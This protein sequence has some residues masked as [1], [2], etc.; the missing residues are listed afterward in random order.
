MKTSFI[1]VYEFPA[2]DGGA[3]RGM[4]DMHTEN[5]SGLTLKVFMDAVE[6]LNDRFKG[7]MRPGAKVN[8]LNIIRLDS[9]Q[10]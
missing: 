8:I 6:V 3:G 10:E 5:P 4:M 2:K 9:D 7:E 1:V